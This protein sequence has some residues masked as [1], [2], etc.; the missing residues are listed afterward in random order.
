M[1][2]ETECTAGIGLKLMAPALKYAVAVTAVT[3]QLH[4]TQW[5]S[6][7]IS[8]V[9]GMCHPQQALSAER[10]RANGKPVPAVV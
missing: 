4:V 7:L 8:L 10:K 6:H 5:Y 1:L 9:H 2:Q 3:A